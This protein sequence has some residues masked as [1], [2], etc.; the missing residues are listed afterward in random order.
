MLQFFRGIIRGIFYARAVRHKATQFKSRSNFKIRK[1]FYYFEFKSRSA[2]V[3]CEMFVM[4]VLFS[5]QLKEAEKSSNRSFQ[6]FKLQFVL[7]FFLIHVAVAG[8]IFYLKTGRNSLF[9]K[10]FGL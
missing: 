6:C 3:L 5:I 9:Y 1:V 4:K 8:K 10:L 7:R 2:T